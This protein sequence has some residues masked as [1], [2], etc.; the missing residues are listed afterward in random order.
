METLQLM[1]TLR[2]YGPVAIGL[3]F[4]LAAVSV[5]PGRVKW[6][7]L[8]A[9]LAILGYETWLRYSNRRGMEKLDRERAELEAR[10]KA[11]SQHGDELEKTVAGLNAQLG[12]LKS[13]QAALDA[14]SADLRQRGGTLAARGDELDRQSSQLGR[15]IDEAQAQRDGAQSVWSRIEEAEHAIELMKRAGQQNG[16]QPAAAARPGEAG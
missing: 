12:Q 5:L 7:V 1:Q 9:G 8:T 14:E 13:R 16:A 10:A 6:Y 11:L 2:D 3:V 4:L 15:Q